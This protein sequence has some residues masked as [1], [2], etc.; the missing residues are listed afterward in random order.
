MFSLLEHSKQ[1][2]HGESFSYFEAAD[3]VHIEIDSSVS[4]LPPRIDLLYLIN[5][6]SVRDT[7][8]ITIES[9][10]S[11][12][13]DT[14]N[15]DWESSYTDFIEQCDPED[16]ADIKIHIKKSSPVTHFQYI[17]LISFGNIMA[18]AKGRTMSFPFSQTA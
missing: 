16:Q 6:I 14:G 1:L 17:L 10:V 5:N 3:N 4:S 13:Y 15:A 7:L 18:T 9:V 2:F 11:F 12:R 8:T